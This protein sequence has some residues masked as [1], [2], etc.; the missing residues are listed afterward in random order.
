MCYYQAI[1]YAIRHGLAR[2]EAGAQGEH[3]LAR[4]YL[5]E[6]TYSVHHLIDPALRRAVDQFL[7]RERRSVDAACEALAEYGPYRKAPADQA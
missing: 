2:V 7:E 3:K 1:D 5:P 4:G 6:K